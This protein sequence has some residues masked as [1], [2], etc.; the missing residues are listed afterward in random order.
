MHPPSHSKPLQSA[1]DVRIHCI[2]NPTSNEKPEVDIIA[3]N[4]AYGDWKSTWTYTDNDFFWL[5]GALPSAV[6][7]ARIL[8]CSHLPGQE[9]VED[10]LLWDLIDDRQRNNRSH[11]PMIFIAH[12]LGGASAKQLFIFSSLSRNSRPETQQFHS[13]VKGF[14]F[15]GS[16]QNG[17]FPENLVKWSKMAVS[18]SRVVFPSKAFEIDFKKVAQVND[19]F[20]LIGGNQV[21]TVCF[22]ETRKT[23]YPSPVSDVGPP[24]LS[25]YKVSDFRHSKIEAVDTIERLLKFCCDGTQII[26][27]KLNATASYAEN[28]EIATTHANLCKFQGPDDGELLRVLGS[29]G[30]LVDSALAW[31]GVVDRTPKSNSLAVS[32]SGIRVL[33]LDGGGVRGL[34]TILVLESLMEAVRLIDR[35]SDVDALKPYLYFDLICGTSTGGLL[36]IMLG[37]LRMDI[38]SCHQAYRSLSSLIFQRRSFN[39]PGRKWWDA[40]RNNPW[41]DG[42]AL[43]EAIKRVVS[44]RL[45]L[46][47][48]SDLRAKS[49]D[50]KEA[51]LCRPLD[52]GGKCF[53]CTI[54]DR[55]HKCRRL[56]SYTARNEVQGHEISIW[57]AARATSAAPLYFPPIEIGGT[58]YFDG[59]MQSNNPIAEVVKEANLEYPNRPFDAI[60]SIGTGT[61]KASG[62]GGGLVNFVSSLVTRVTNTEAKDEEFRDDFR[63]L[64]DVYFRLQELGTLGEIDLADHEKMD[65]VERLAR[66]YLDSRE[67][68][69]QILACATK[70][71]K[72]RPQS[73]QVQDP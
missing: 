35:P 37:R 39:I 8:S 33:A 15:F 31:G 41:Y 64:C 26:L 2:A 65:E 62:P 28:R 58:L 18:I 24:R 69:A 54:A 73:N 40:Y 6:P 34:F 30:R 22:Y 45:S 21:P 12:S 60:I 36:A 67:G 11:V 51:L 49:I 72:S 66:Q 13:L 61:S 20:L 38:K 47:E 29:T 44:E 27:P 46:A 59:G 17:E 53:V 1:R 48:Q 19:D 55:E 4:G 14:V 57:Q 3:I 71:A 7:H 52:D 10:G 9:N 32:S 42:Q 68:Q 50:V 70:L 23:A 56:R 16:L 43:E 63:G 5:K 25:R